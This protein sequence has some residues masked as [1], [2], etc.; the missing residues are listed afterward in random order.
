[1]AA[2]SANA[3]RSKSLK[4]KA[5]STNSASRFVVA[6]LLL[7]F[8][9]IAFKFFVASLLLVRPENTIS[10]WEKDKQQASL[11]DT[12]Q[13]LTRIELAEK[14]AVG[15]FTI[16]DPIKINELKSRLFLINTTLEQS[17]N[18]YKQAHQFSL[19][20]T[21]LAPSHYLGWTLLAQTQLSNPD[22]NW[23]DQNALTRAL[24]TGPFERKNQVRLLP[25][26]IEH[27]SLL[28]AKNQELAR[29]MLNSSLNELHT[30]Y[31]A[32]RAMRKFNNASTF[33]ELLASSKYHER[34]AKELSK[35]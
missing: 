20:L 28:N 33:S 8:F 5:L 4:S 19:Q 16:N 23:N 34:L 10:Q 2:E 27:W 31:V 14:S 12:K 13:I 21:E 11:E 24:E 30:A 3:R 29:V 17:Q 9:F 1:M 32:I 22:Y 35:R 6:I 26:L 7:A 15:A 18:H 25:L